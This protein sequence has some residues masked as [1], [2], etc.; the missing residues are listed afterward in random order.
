MTRVLS[1]LLYWLVVVGLVTLL[2]D[3]PVRIIR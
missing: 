3:P 2:L 1:L